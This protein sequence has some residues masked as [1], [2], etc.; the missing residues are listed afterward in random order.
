MRKTKIEYGIDLG[1]TNS[2]IATLKNGKIKIIKNPMNQ[3]EVTLSYIYFYKNKTIVGDKAK[4]KLEQENLNAFRTRTEITEKNGFI[5]FKRTMGTD[6]EYF[7]PIRERAYSSEELSAEVLKRLKSYV[8]DDELN[9]VVITVPMRFS[10][11]Q[12]DATQRAA[13]LAGFEH[14]ELL[15]EPIAAAT[16][17]G[18][19]SNDING[20]FLVF[21]FGGGT[22]D[23]ALMRVEDRIMKVVDTA[24]DN[25]LGGKDIDKAIVNDILISHLQ[26]E[27]EIDDII[28][29][30][31]YLKLLKEVVKPFAE[32]SK[33]ALSKKEDYTLDSGEPIEQDEIGKIGLFEKNITRKDF[34][35]VTKHILQRSIDITKKLLKEN[36]LKGTDLETILLVGGTTYIPILRRMIKEQITDKID[37]SIDPMTAVSRGAALYAFTKDVPEYIQDKNRDKTKIQLFLEYPETT[38]ET[39]VKLGMKIERDKM[40]GRIPEIFQIEVIRSDK[41]W[42]SGIFKITDSEI[43]DIYLKENE[44]NNFIIFLFDKKNAPY[45]CEPN[46]FNI[47]QGFIPPD[48][49]LPIDL[50]IGISDE[51]NNYERLELIKGL[52]KNTPIKNYIK[53]KTKIL[54]TNQDI[55]PGKKE[56]KIRIPIYEGEPS[57]RS[58]YNKRRAEVII[59]GNDITEFLPKDSDVKISLKIDGSRRKAELTAYFPDI[60]ETVKVDNIELKQRTREPEEIESMINEAKAELSYFEKENIPFDKKLQNSTNQM[61]KELKNDRDDTDTIHKGLDRMREVWK[62]IDRIND[63]HKFPKMKKEISELLDEL[64][65]INE[66]YGDEETTKIQNKLRKQADQVFENKDTKLAQDFIKELRAFRFAIL[67]TRI[68]YWMSI[69]KYYDDNFDECDWINKTAAKNLINEAKDVITGI[70]PTAEKLEPITFKLWDLLPEGKPPTDK[71]IKELLKE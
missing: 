16:A 41:G 19:E 11:L 39:D 38:V 23:V 26:K 18:M 40:E 49:I 48:A 56:D 25:H 67:R 27:Y 12:I 29:N 36:K 33:I 20:Y 69:I 1:T 42:S 3:K 71:L 28:N 6:K 4:N 45:P 37:T 30:N 43:I 2:S 35:K 17:F 63:K 31:K 46:S 59:T 53:G 51:E 10:S 13:E 54:H 64:D 21:D 8:M 70:E 47:L 32:E 15:E 60:D 14:C 65:V 5:E 9:T 7:C 50:C 62:E 66:R 44:T 55:R 68:E 61:G 22:F 52:E 58:I 57:T 24:G 34:E